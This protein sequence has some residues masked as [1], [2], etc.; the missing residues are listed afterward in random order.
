VGDGVVDYGN[1]SAGLAQNTTAGGVDDSQTATNNGNIAEDFNIKT[2]TPAGWTLGASPGT[3]IFVHEFS[4]NGGSNWTKFSTP[5]IYQTLV[6]NIAA[7]S[8]QLF[9]LR[10]TAPNPSTSAAQK[11][12][13]ITVQAVQD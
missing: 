4:T 8:S 10:L 7:S 9:D 5:D 3:D 12:V 11:T 6:S 2:S 13:T 1:L